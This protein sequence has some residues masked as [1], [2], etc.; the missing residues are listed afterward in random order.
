M[1]MLSDW[2]DSFNIFTGR[3]GLVGGGLGERMVG[4]RMFGFAFVLCGGTICFTADGPPWGTGVGSIVLGLRCLL[5]CSLLIDPGFP[6]ISSGQ[7]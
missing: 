7:N 6:M 3:P 1:A 5:F 4:W 2:S